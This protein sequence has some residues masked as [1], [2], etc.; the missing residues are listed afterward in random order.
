MRRPQRL[1]AIAII[2]A[3]L[4][5]TSGLAGATAHGPSRARAPSAL[6]ASTRPVAAPTV[7]VGVAKVGNKTETILVNSRG[8]PLYIYRF[9]STKRSLVT[10]SLAALWPPLVSGA[11][12]TK[13]LSGKLTV[14]NTTNRQQVA[15]NGHFLYTFADDT[16][17]HVTG[18]GVQNF[19]VATP[20]LTPLRS[21]T[22]A[23]TGS[24][25]RSGAPGGSGY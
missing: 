14:A 17:G 23:H 1:G 10:G 22:S 16:P 15:F 3:A 13:G 7:R 6:A 19:F 20:G 25:P 18:Q 4:I 24:L 5:P 11:S 21:G 12:I 9:D 2:G 8:L